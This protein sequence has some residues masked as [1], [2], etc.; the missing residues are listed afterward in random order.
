MNNFGDFGSLGLSDGDDLNF[1]D[2]GFGNDNN[3]DTD[4]NFDNGF[5][6]DSNLYS[7]TFDNLSSQDDI[8]LDPVNDSK[9]KAII[10]TIIGIAAV[11]II[12]VLA[13]I[14]TRAA[15]SKKQAAGIQSGPQISSGQSAGDI[16]GTTYKPTQ[17]Q[18]VNKSNESWIEITSGENV[19]FS[20]DYAEMTFTITNIRH[21]TRVVDTNKNLVVKTTLQGSISGLSGTYEL[22]IPY[23]KGVKL[24]VG[25]SFTVYVQLGSLNF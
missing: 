9:K 25:N 20:A 17:T 14:I 23:N 2:L 8:S 1:D 7:G 13:I 15:D 10:V 6:D 4:S 24:V 12:L 5:D 18:V 16:L 22:D 19:V 3:L 11:F 21:L